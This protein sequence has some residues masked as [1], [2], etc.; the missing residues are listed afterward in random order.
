MQSTQIIKADAHLINQI[1][2]KYH[3]FPP[4]ESE[5]FVAINNEVIGIIVSF[6]SEQG[7]FLTSFFVDPAWRNQGIGKELLS[8]AMKNKERVSLYTENK[9]T[10]NK[11][12]IH[13]YKQLGFVPIWNDEKETLWK[14]E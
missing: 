3:I 4:E 2:T 9:R 8:A 1:Q 12:A 13:L 14:K 6:T 10:D 7:C 11:A 5:T